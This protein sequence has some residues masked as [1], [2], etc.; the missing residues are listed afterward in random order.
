M[1]YLTP[2][3]RARKNLTVRT[4]TVVRRILFEGTRAVGA[5]IARGGET[6]TARGREIIL[7][8]GAIHS[9]A[10]LMRSGIGA[11][12]VLAKHGVEVVAGLPG[13]GRNLIEHPS[14]SVSCYLHHHGRLHNLER[15]HTQAQVR[16]S[17]KLPGI[18]AG[19]MCLAVLARSGWHA[20]GRR[21]ASLF[22]FVNRASSQGP[23]PWRSAAPRDEPL[24]DFRMLTTPP[25]PV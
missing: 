13:V 4:E 18:P 16:F 9:P 17:S 2:A 8:R 10:M 15:H 20:L 11:P 22:F 6:E 25:H 5:E 19:D 21:V 1:A 23:V 3:V 24:V 12:D 14:V 7:T